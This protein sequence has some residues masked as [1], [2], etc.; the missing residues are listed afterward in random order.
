MADNSSTKNITPVITPTGPGWNRTPVEGNISLRE[1]PWCGKI[2]LR[3]NPNDAQFLN[4]A[5]EALGMPLPVDAG[6]TSVGT[7]AASDT[8]AAETK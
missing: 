8:S 5:G 3:G 2:N 1:R 4:A 6:T 7:S